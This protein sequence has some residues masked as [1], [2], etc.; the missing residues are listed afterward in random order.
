MAF[1]RKQQKEALEHVTTELLGQEGGD[2]IPS[3]LSNNGIRTVLDLLPLTQEEIQGLTYKDS[4][5]EPSHL[6]RGDIGLLRALQAY[7]TH[8]MKQVPLNDLESWKGL[9][10]DDFDAF[11]ISPDYHASISTSNPQALGTLT[12]PSKTRDPVIDFKRGIK[13][14]I[15]LYQPLKSDS[16]WD[17]WQRH[18]MSQARAQGVEDILDPTYSPP[19][20]NEALFDEKQKY[21]FAVFERTLLT[22]K[23][24]A[25]LRANAV[26]YD[27]QKTYRELKAYSLTS[28]KALLDSSKLLSYITSVR[29]GDVS[30]KGTAHAF[31]LNW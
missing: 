29:I 13:R 2:P 27:A 19:A 18:M 28:T 3:A 17:S 11:R 6:L 14:D 21:M 20:G 30:W 24:K 8:I 4:S 31:L 22:D 12:H 10:T 23:G 25:I 5:G 15:N 26:S 9:T 1:T 16:Q 7:S